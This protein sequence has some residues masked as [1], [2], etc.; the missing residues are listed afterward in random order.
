MQ[1]ENSGM[2]QMAVRYGGYIKMWIDSEQVLDNWRQCW[3]PATVIV[4][5]N[6]GRKHAIRMEWIPDGGE[7]FFSCRWL[8][9]ANSKEASQFVWTSSAARQINY[10]LVYGSSMD[11]V[12]SGY[13]TL[14]GKATIPPRWAFGFWQSRERYQNTGRNFQYGERIPEEKNSDGQYRARLELLESRMN[15]AA[16]NFDASRFPMPDSMIDV[17]HRIYHA[18]FMISVWPKF[19]E[20]IPTYNDF[21]KKDGC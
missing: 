20:G 2:H 17:L 8:R 5:F 19:Y 4:K 18:H 11:D 7:S 21:V 9:P 15:G 16:R 1:T 6:G 3:N 12:I 10:Y 13:R 14:T